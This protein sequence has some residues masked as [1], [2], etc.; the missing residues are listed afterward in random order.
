MELY[1]SLGYDILAITDHRR[2]TIPQDVPDGLLMLPGIELDYLLPGQ[3]VHLVGLGITKDIE[4]RWNRQGEPCDGLADILACGGL[5]ILAHPAWSMNDPAMMA[6]LRGV[7]AVEI[8]NSTSGLPYNAPRAD[9]S[10]LLDTLWANY[11]DSLMPVVG[12]DD[13]HNY[14][15]E[16]AAGWTMI[17]AEELTVSSVLDA[18]RHGRIYATQGPVFERLE[19]TADGLYVACSPCDTIVFYSN[20]PWVANR[21]RCVKGQ[22]EALYQPAARDR[23]VRV[24]IIDEKGR[25]A[26]SMPVDL[27]S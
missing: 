9:S 18:I 13:T 21:S 19:L 6:S 17:D 2:L 3:A 7:S 8:W 11:P 24:Q 15:A 5:C 12:S 1:R 22:R 10:S 4:D 27:R 20:T 23:F 25:S 16:V 14:G 26:W